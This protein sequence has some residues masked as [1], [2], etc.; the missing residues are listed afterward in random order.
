MEEDLYRAISP[1][2]HYDHVT[3]YLRKIAF[4][5]RY[6]VQGFERA[7]AHHS[8]GCCHE[9]TSKSQHEPY[10]VR[11]PHDKECNTHV[12]IYT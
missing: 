6:P 12:C 10:S 4:E 7:N 2:Y 5:V 3:E 11:E 8:Q 9:Q 1:K